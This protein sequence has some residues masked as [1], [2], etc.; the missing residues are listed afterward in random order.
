MNFIKRMLILLALL[1]AGWG[2]AQS[3]PLSTNS[4]AANRVLMVDASSMPLTLGRATLTIG[5]L[6]RTNGVYTG[7]YRV[8][9]FPYFFKNE[10]GKLSITVSDES[11]AQIN[12]GI[13]TEIS[14]TATTRGKD[15][16]GRPIAATVMP[17][18]IN[19]GTLK[20]WFTVGDRKMVFEPAYHF[21]ENATPVVLAHTIATNLSPPRFL[22]VIQKP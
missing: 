6:E 4:A 3:G 5:L 1:P 14:A 19:H 20:V 11:M 10:R 22:V 9:V 12:M 21:A 16:M 17:V 8:K 2:H 13:M 7:N 18:D 15:A